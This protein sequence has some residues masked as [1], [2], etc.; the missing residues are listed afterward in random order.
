[1]M[2]KNQ[3]SKIYKSK[4]MMIINLIKKIKKRVK[5]QNKK[6]IET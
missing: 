2:L 1:M 5:Y 6:K 4:S 3:K